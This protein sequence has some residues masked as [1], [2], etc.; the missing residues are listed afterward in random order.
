MSYKEL[1]YPSLSVFSLQYRAPYID[2]KRY[3][4]LRN[5][6][7]PDKKLGNVD[8]GN[9]ILDGKSAQ[10]MHNIPAVCWLPD[11]AI[12]CNNYYMQSH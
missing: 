4:R 10:Q 1:H 9:N 8:T 3:Q 2:Q 5:L 11:L 12:L 7:L 6:H